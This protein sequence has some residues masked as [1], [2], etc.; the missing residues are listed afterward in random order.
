[1]SKKSSDGNDGLTPEQIAM[2]KNVVRDPVLFASHV[3]GLDLWPR[4]AEILR[5]IKTQRR[6]AIKACHSVGKT[7]TLAV[8][9][10]W[11]LARYREGIVLT[12]SSTQR[13]V[14]TQ[15]WLEIHRLTKGAKV[16]YPELRSTEIK[17]RD[18]NNFAIGF[19]TNQSENFQGYHGK[20]V[21]IIADEAPGIESGIW[22]AVA[23]TMA[24]GVVHIV[25]AGNP[26]V[27]SGAF[28]DAFTRERGLWNCHTIG[29]FDTPNL[30]GLTLE[31]LLEMDPSED[32]PLDHNPIP[33]LVTK[34]W[35]YDQHQTWWHGDEASSPNWMSR[36]LAE[37]PS[38]AEDALFKMIWLER[39]RQRAI[40]IPS[41]G[42]PT[43]LPLFAGVDVGGGTAET[44]A[45]V[46][47]FREDR[48]RIV[49]MGAWRGQDTRGQVVRFLSDFR[50]RLCLVN[51]DAIG[52]GYNFA[53]HLQSERFS[54]AM[55]N[56]SLPCESKPNLGENDP[57]RRFVNLKAC[58]Y[59]RLADLFERDQ[60]DGLTDEETIGQLAGIRWELDS[61]GRIKIESK[62]RARGRGEPSPDR[63]EGLMLAVCKPPREYGYIPAPPQQHQTDPSEGGPELADFL[64]DFPSRTGRGRL[65]GGLRQGALGRSLRRNPGAW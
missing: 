62:E 63:A 52:I 20:Y 38:Q 14:R 1:M 29:V 45:Y 61:H 44:V 37:F 13:Q 41:I 17:F 5:S 50:T 60:V 19:S 3:L 42:S 39:A 28:Y 49:G 24:G 47:E 26:T 34:R 15:L 36:V 40:E 18:E 46:C 55:V 10:L 64:S 53:L 59:Q 9:A 8:A 11:W 65:F 2:F 7:F 35:V 48:L 22:D 12:T 23:G 21:L 31:Q 16:P 54:V 32:G 56:V 6:T 27:P 25:M 43:N 57:A 51:V 4:E 58:A 33:Y 30:K